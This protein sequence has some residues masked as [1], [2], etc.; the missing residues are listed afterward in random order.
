APGASGRYLRSDGAS[1]FAWSG[2]PGSDLLGGATSYIQNRDTLQASATFYVSSASVYGQTLLA[3]NSGS[4]GIGVGNPTANETYSRLTVGGSDATELGASI[5]NSGAGQVALILRRLGGT[6]SR[7]SMYTPSGSTDLRFYNNVPG[8]AGDKVTFAAGG[9]VGIGTAA[10]G[11]KLDVWGGQIRLYESGSGHSIA[12]RT[13]GTYADLSVS[14]TRLYID[15]QTNEIVELNPVSAGP[16][17]LVRGGGNVG[18]GTDAPAYKLDVQGGGVIRSTGSA[19]FATTSGNVGINTNAPTYKLDVNGGAIV[20]ST[21]TVTNSVYAS[22]SVI[23][24]DMT[25]DPTSAGELQRNGADIKWHDG[26]AVRTLL[27]GGNL[28]TTAI[29]NQNTLQAGSTFYVSSGSVQNDLVVWG[30]LGVGVGVANA[31]IAVVGGI[32]ASGQIR[33]GVGAPDVAENIT[34]SDEAIEAGDIVVA[35]PKH[36]ERIIKSS[37]VYQSG[38]LGII[39]TK[40]GILT[41]ADEGDIDGAITRDKKQRPLALAGRVPVKVSL[42][43]GTIAIGDYLTSSSKPGYAMKATEPG[44]VIGVALDNFDGKNSKEGKVLTFINLGESNLSEKVKTLS[45]ELEAVKL[46]MLKMKKQLTRGG[47]GGK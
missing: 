11:Q 13:D 26:T 47:E 35:D 46:E 24:T 33:G 42:E 16:V 2:I 36:R 7:W 8:P 28:G 22:S 18:V 10:P 34:T 39:S 30:K 23:F 44:S 38:I 29:L 17:F 27:H 41:N 43:N 1:T 9:N 40:P 20:R 15:A 3:R 5:E 45:G 37:R 4:V 21:L 14:G 25:A 12:L 6:A 19:Y 31:K 32:S